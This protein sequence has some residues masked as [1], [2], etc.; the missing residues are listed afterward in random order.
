MKQQ[1]NGN[2]WGCDSLW[3]VAGIGWARECDVGSLK[4]VHFLAW[5]LFEVPFC[6]YSLKL[7]ALLRLVNISDTEMQGVKNSRSMLD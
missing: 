4:G 3:R 2:A 6:L 7:E 5:F 1:F